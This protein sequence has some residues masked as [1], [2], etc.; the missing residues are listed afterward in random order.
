MTTGP[1]AGNW[2]MQLVTANSDQAWQLSGFLLQSGNSLTGSFISSPNATTGLGCNGVG[3]VNG[4]LNGQTLKLDVNVS[5]Q[6][7]SLSGTFPSTPPS[8]K[9]PLTGQF[10]T[11]AAGCTSSSATGTWSAVPVT[12]LTGS[13]HGTFTSNING[14]INVAGNLDQGPNVGTSNATLSGTINAT[15]PANFCSYLNSA[16]ITGL[17]SG[18][19]VSLDLF[20]P[21]GSQIGQ[22]GPP[23]TV[24]PDGKSLS[25]SPDT[26]PPCTYSFTQISKSCTGDGGSVQL[27]FP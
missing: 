24:T 8:S 1:A 14:P 18:T 4:T 27:T 23:A 6:D 22:I 12:P 2:Q 17:I 13:F 5:S 9:T 19:Q 3:S 16:T 10:T 7:V 21:D 26:T 20:G 25:C 11:L 15:G